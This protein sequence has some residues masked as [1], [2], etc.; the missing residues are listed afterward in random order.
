MG[1]RSSVRL[2]GGGGGGGGG[3]GVG[4]VGGGG[5]G[6][7]GGGRRRGGRGQSTC[8]WSRRGSIRFRCARLRGR[9]RCGATALTGSSAGSIRPWRS[10]RAGGRRSSSWRRRAGS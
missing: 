9:W 8:C 6:G 10:W 5:G 3:G 2:W 4:G 7:W 1:I